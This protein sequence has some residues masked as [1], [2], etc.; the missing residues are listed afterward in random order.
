MVA[1][2]PLSGGDQGGMVWS[3]H[4]INWVRI[5]QSVVVELGF[6]GWVEFHNH[7]MK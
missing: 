4:E 2:F 6:V 7:R 3:L 5:K 1:R